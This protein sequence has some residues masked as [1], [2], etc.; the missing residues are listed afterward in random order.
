MS[1]RLASEL[2]P[3]RRP[4]TKIV[5]V[6]KRR[7]HSNGPHWCCGHYPKPKGF[8][9]VWVGGPVFASAPTLPGRWVLNP[10]ATT[11]RTSVVPPTTQSPCVGSGSRLEPSSRCASL[12]VL[13][14]SGGA[15]EETPPWMCV[16]PLPGCFTRFDECHAF[17]RLVSLGFSSLFE[18]ELRF[19]F[20]IA[21]TRFFPRHFDHASLLELAWSDD[22]SPLP[23]G[24]HLYADQQKRCEKIFALMADAR[25]R[26]DAVRAST[27]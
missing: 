5:R 18:S 13:R 24:K 19:L 8:S 25:S 16:G 10:L 12:V 6:T 15:S 20:R 2:P 26:V 11:R 22:H 7:L 1:F 23:Q 14:S 27:P 9:I 21:A 17:V 3:E 4:A